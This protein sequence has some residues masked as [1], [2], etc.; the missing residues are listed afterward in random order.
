[1]FG[2]IETGFII[3][4]VFIYHFNMSRINGAY[5]K[6]EEKENE[7]DFYAGLYFLILMLLV[8]VLVGVVMYFGQNYDWW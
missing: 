6:N 4:L 1:M 2:L 8:G 3:R 7:K 5:E